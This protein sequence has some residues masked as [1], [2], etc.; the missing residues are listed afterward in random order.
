[1]HVAGLTIFG[2]SLPRDVTRSFSTKWSL[3]DQVQILAICDQL[4]KCFSTSRVQNGSKAL[5]IKLPARALIYAL[6]QAKV[7]FLLNRDNL[8]YFNLFLVSTE[9]E[10]MKKH[11][12]MLLYVGL[13]RYVLEQ[14]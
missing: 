12:A 2:F 1:M 5:N 11:Y 6:W 7:Q 3:I 14:K 10:L 8:T 9:K 4:K 13:M